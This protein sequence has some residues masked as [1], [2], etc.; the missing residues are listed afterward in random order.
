MIREYF[1][2]VLGYLWYRTMFYLGQNTNLLLTLHRDLEAGLNVTT[3]TFNTLR[4]RTKTR[5]TR[6]TIS[7]ESNFI[8]NENRFIGSKVE[9]MNKVY[10]NKI[11][12]SKKNK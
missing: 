4:F 5:F 10:M 2:N 12:T 7:M 3:P 8:E 11:I 1:Q 6:Y 9:V